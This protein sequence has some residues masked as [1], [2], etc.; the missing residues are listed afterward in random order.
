[1]SCVWPA[2]QYARDL[3][4]HDRLGVDCFVVEEHMASPNATYPIVVQCKGLEKQAFD[5]THLDDALKSIRKVA[6]S[7]LPIQEYWLVINRFIKETPLRAALRTDLDDL[8]KSGAVGKAVL[9]NHQDFL[10]SLIELL[11][12]W[13]KLRLLERNRD[14]LNQ[15]VNALRNGIEYV[16]DVPFRDQRGADRNP[17]AKLAA[18]MSQNV[19]ESGGRA[20]GMEHASK[21][22]RFV[23]SE[24]GFGKTSLLLDLTRKLQG[25]SVFY[26]PVAELDKK[27]FQN[28]FELTKSLYQRVCPEDSADIVA[29]HLPLVAFRELIR[30]DPQFVLLLDGLDE[31]RA[32]YR[33]SSLCNVF[34][35]LRSFASDIVIAARKEYF[36]SFRGSIDLAMRRSGKNRRELYLEE[37]DTPLIAEFLRGFQD[38]P[39]IQRFRSLVNA[40]QYE[41]VYGDI[42]KRPL[43]L[44]MLATD[45][46]ADEHCATNLAELYE[47]YFHEK[48]D[49]DVL[50]PFSFGEGGGRALSIEGLDRNSLKAAVFEI[51]ENIAR[52]M[53]A[54]DEAPSERIL[55]RESVTEAE[56]IAEIQ[57]K[58]FSLTNLADL[59][60]NSL[61]VTASSRSGRHGLLLRFA[62]TSFLEFFAASWMMRH[63]PDRMLS[64]VD[65]FPE[66]VARFAKHMPPPGG[67]SGR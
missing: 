57:A 67:R 47:R 23:L 4:W 2:A 13:I 45:L 1:M 6:K 20:T 26:Q 8:E 16:P 44:Q 53:M 37:W 59:L 48:L 22:Y 43:F 25:R 64:D 49:R 3:G 63:E 14:C 12:P 54:P 15:Y 5:E 62:H 21:A 31:H 65:L 35:S 9:L 18:S 30:Y 29:T 55:L 42:P 58:G 33:E 50:T 27:S 28:E 52:A 32:A 7:G 61:L 46:A 56:V 34:G 36:E 17:S 41:S 24:F 60:Q 10:V 51:L 66:G 38:S 11:I 40:G 19:R 39:G